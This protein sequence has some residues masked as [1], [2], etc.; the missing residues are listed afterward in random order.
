MSSTD[1][2][3]G[4]EPRPD[5]E[6]LTEWLRHVQDDSD[7]RQEVLR[8]SQDRLQLIVRRM[9]RD[10]PGVD[11][12][13]DTGAILN[14]V[15][16]R[17]D[18]AMCAVR[19]NTSDDFFRLATTHVRYVLLSMA[20]RYRELISRYQTPSPDGSDTLHSA[21]NEP[22]TTD[23]QASA[24]LWEELFIQVEKL[25][26]ALRQVFEL[27]WYHN[28]PRNAVSQMLGIC[29]KTVQRRLIRATSLLQDRMDGQLPF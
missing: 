21:Q 16:L 23:H 12:H 9:L 1:E 19:L 22:A 28:M 24:D 5:E 18:R 13:E 6:T 26:D 8:R 3:I 11:R 27:S 2:P 25:P 29:E 7:L 17:M 4:P 20:R 14:D 10:F 15:L